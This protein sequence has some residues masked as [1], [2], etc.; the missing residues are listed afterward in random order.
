MFDENGIIDHIHELEL[1]IKD[2]ERYQKLSIHELKHD[3]DKQNMVLHAM[4]IAIQS[5]I[6]IS[7][8]II[9]EQK[10]TPPSSYRESFIILSENQIIDHKLSIE[11]AKLASFRNYL[12]HVYF[13]LNLNIVY[14]IL[15]NDLKYLIEFLN[16]IKQY[17]RKS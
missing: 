1:S 4:L 10:L 15:Q 6:D 13:K 2:W 11:L 8:H 9:S 16:I 17:L 3:R 12:V 5:S 14:N 7:N